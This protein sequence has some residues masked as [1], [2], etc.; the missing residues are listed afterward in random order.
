MSADGGADLAY[1]Q[2]VLLQNQNFC[3]RPAD[4]MNK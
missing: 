2:I 4:T 1:I 3:V